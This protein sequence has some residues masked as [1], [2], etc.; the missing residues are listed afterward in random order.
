MAA[1][2]R[3]S[4]MDGATARVEISI[5]QEKVLSRKNPE[6]T[7][8][9]LLQKIEA[10]GV[11]AILT[12]FLSLRKMEP[13]KKIE[14]YDE[15]YAE[16]EFELFHDMLHPCP[17]TRHGGNTNVDPRYWGMTL[18]QFNEIVDNLSGDSILV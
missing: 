11:A 15:K 10:V 16:G 7:L 2:L 5:K 18:R 1:V 4:V 6:S 17:L 8:Q 12:M 14:S 9:K 13:P 3:S